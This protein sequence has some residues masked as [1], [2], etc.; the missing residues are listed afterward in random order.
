MVVAY[1]ARGSRRSRGSA[2][3]RQRREE[4]RGR[5]VVHGGGH[6]SRYRAER[7]TRRIRIFLES[8][9]AEVTARAAPRAS[10][11]AR[12]TRDRVGRS[13]KRSPRLEHPE[14]RALSRAPRAPP[15]HAGPETQAG[16]GDLRGL[17]CLRAPARDAPEA[18]T[19]VRE[20]SRAR[21][22]KKHRGKRKEKRGVS[23]AFF[24]F[25]LTPTARQ[26]SI[27]TKF[28]H[29]AFRVRS[30]GKPQKTTAARRFH[31]RFQRRDGFKDATV[32]KTYTV[33]RHRSNTEVPV[34]FAF[35]VFGNSHVRVSR[36]T[37]L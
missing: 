34:E 29:T 11:R 21:L 18:R 5:D 4:P 9:S 13:E 30:S 10:P 8:R 3:E 28:S 36:S 26:S 1:R 6:V 37:R 27:A 17:S 19:A 12:K 35:F 7:R 32:S 31:R 2:R 24:G 20:C 33:K 22:E 25:R 15:P 14:T 16:T 23:R